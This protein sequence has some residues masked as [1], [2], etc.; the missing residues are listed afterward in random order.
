MRCALFFQL[1]P[2]LT[3]EC[4]RIERVAEERGGAWLVDRKD[5]N[6]ENNHGMGMRC[7]LFGLEDSRLAEM[8]ECRG[9][10]KRFAK[11]R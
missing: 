6:E 11:S 9:W 2:K 5:R 7:D 3:S 4:E 8:G 10:I 1:F